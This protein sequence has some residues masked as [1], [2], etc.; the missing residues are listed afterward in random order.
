VPRAVAVERDGIRLEP[1][2]AAA[3]LTGV[4]AIV[5]GSVAVALL[6]AP[7]L[8]RHGGAAGLAVWAA[9]WIARTSERRLR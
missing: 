3:C 7:A 5:L 9:C 1:L 4:F 2:V 6:V 8:A